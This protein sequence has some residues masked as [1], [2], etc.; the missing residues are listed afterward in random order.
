MGIEST[1]L[2]VG[3]TAF[4]A[5][6][7]SKHT[8]GPVEQKYLAAR[9][10]IVAGITAAAGPT[11]HVPVQYSVP[12]ETFRSLAFTDAKAKGL[13]NPA[14]SA[15]LKGRL[16]QDLRHH[17]LHLNSIAPGPND[18]MIINANRTTAMQ[19]AANLFTPDT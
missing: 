3:A 8:V 16:S 19:G 5:A 7:E 13:D 11:G 10:D 9:A 1:V 2:V 18:T 14:T 4:A 15:Y 17:G 12:C 6:S